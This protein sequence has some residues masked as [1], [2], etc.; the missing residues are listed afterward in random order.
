M[1]RIRK[2]V[3]ITLFEIS[4]QLQ[5]QNHQKLNV[6][7][8]EGCAISITEQFLLLDCIRKVFAQKR[9]LLTA[10]FPMSPIFSHFCC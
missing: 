10:V 7:T 1:L 3:Y 9:H 5:Q 8:I 4:Y 6:K 2:T